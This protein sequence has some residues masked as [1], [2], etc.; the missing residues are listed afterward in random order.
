MRPPAKALETGPKRSADHEIA[1]RGS[2]PFRCGLSAFDLKL[3]AV[4]SLLLIPAF[5]AARVPFRLNFPEFAAL[6]WGAL[7]VRSAFVTALLVIAGFP[8]RRTLLPFLRRYWRQKLR[9]LIA[10]AVAI[11]LSCAF[12]LR[13]GLILAVAALALAEL[14]ERKR[15]RFESTLVDVFWPGLYLFCGMIVVLALNAALMGIRYFASY[16][17]AL[18]HLD[19][20]LFHANVSAMSHW[21]LSHIP[22]WLAVVLEVSYFGLFTQIGATLCL[23]A[24]L[25]S[26]SY[27]VRLVRAILIAYTFTLTIFF[28]WPSTSPYFICPDHLSAFPHYLTAYATQQTLMENARLL[29]THAIPPGAYTIGGYYISFPCMHIAQALISLWFLRPW[30]KIA[31][32][33][34]AFDAVLLIPAIVLLE[35]HYII[36]LFAGAAVACVAIWISGRVAVKSTVGE[37]DPEQR[38]PALVY[39]A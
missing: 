35:W 37:A 13:F 12:G 36:G 2:Y 23:G 5:I 18:H 28:L 21:T 29:W 10:L 27:A 20:I 4:L 16:D 6:Y 22:R 14:M 19:W 7:A 11:E 33:V 1:K 25:K 17:Q 3:L 31:G 32:L 9:I 24:I 15:A 38:E 34:L 30:R 26:Q 39:T 8:L